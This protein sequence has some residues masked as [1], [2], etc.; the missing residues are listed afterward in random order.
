MYIPKK[1]RKFSYTTVPNTD[2]T[3]VDY[4]TKAISELYK[5]VNSD[6]DETTFLGKIKFSKT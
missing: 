1:T 2:Q 3:I 4:Q 6:N 5:S